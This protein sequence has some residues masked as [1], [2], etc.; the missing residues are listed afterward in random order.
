MKYRDCASREVSPVER[1]ERDWIMTASDNAEYDAE[2]PGLVF[3]SCGV[4]LGI[5]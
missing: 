2:D 1:D 5:I 3:Q 4:G